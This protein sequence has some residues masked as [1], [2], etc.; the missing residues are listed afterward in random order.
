MKKVWHII[1]ATAATIA[2]LLI[3]LSFS[4]GAF[5]LSIL[6]FKH[7]DA[8]KAFQARLSPVMQQYMFMVVTILIVFLLI[9]TVGRL[10]A[11][12]F[13]RSNMHPM[14]QLINAIRQLGK[15]DFDI[16]IPTKPNMRRE[17][18][19]LAESINDMAAGL[20]ELER[21]RLEFVSNVSHEIQSP[22][23]SISGYSLA[24]RSQPDMEA[25]ERARILEIIELEST[26]LSRLS[27]NL[28]KL[29]SLETAAYPHEVIEYR[30]DRQLRTLI[31]ACE[32]QW[33][34]KKL[35]MDV[36]L[37]E[38]TVK[39]NEDALS[40]VWVNVLHNA[41]KF[42]PEGGTI[43]VQLFA[44]CDSI[45]VSIADNGIGIAEEDL[46]HLFERFFKADKARVRSGSGSGSGLGLSI[47]HKIVELHGGEMRVNS[48]LG[49]GSEFAVVLPVNP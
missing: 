36:Q 49:Q 32:P 5:W 30:L 14:M 10:I 44:R 43:T 29:S 33:S 35:E 48:V 4:S 6:I 23:T 26:R 39:A 2:L 27:D 24:L 31:L 13:G 46:P 1:Q 42:T 22:L 40:Q 7:V 21:M 15:G 37:A 25:E 47:A 41:I 17:F 45:E 9:A 19:E 18:G 12:I 38:M 16:Q 20:K 11:W 34:G 3:I 28:L 8:A